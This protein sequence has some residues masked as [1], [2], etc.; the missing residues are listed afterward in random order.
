MEIVNV[1]M[2][3]FFLLVILYIVAQ[4]FLK[5]IKLLWKLI[6]NSAIGLILLLVV[7]YFGAFLSFKIGINII[8]VLIAGFLGIPGLLLLI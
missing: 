5:P 6:F 7:N 3:A 1:I 8:T 2:A 4:V